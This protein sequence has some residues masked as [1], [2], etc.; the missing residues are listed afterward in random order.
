MERWRE[1]EG[2]GAAEGSGE[3][4]RRASAADADSCPTS[5]H[6]SRKLLTAVPTALWLRCRGPIREM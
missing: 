6:Y 1:G 4:Q 3:G 2:G 5:S